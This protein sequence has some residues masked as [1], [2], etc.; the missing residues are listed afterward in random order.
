[1][2]TPCLAP[3]EVADSTREICLRSYIRRVH[4]RTR[5]G[6]LDVPVSECYLDATGALVFTVHAPEGYDIVKLEGAQ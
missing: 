1:M 6:S 5:Y 4:I 3:E 2:S